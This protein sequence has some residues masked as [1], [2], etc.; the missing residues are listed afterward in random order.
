[1]PAFRITTGQGVRQANSTP[2]A[3]P[4]PCFVR[5]DAFAA[6]VNSTLLPV[7][8]PLASLA[9]ARS[10]LR[11]RRLLSALLCSVPAGLNGSPLPKL[12]SPLVVPGAGGGKFVADCGDDWCFGT[13]GGPG[14][15]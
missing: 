4:T 2:E 5:K 1:M 7:P 11:R 15:V 6:Y 12:P 9:C 13:G 10:A 3:I 8:P 14:G